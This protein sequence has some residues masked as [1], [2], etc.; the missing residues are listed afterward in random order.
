[1]KQILKK[2]LT[3]N[4]LWKIQNFNTDIDKLTFDMEPDM[5]EYDKMGNL[6]I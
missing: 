6:V 2:I 3:E 4:L 1:M 5:L